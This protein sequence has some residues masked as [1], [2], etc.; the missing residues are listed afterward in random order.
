MS[1]IKYVYANKD[2]LKVSTITVSGESGG[3]NLSAACALYAK[4]KG[5]LEIIDGTV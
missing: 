1:G 4:R 5:C 3:G 2:V